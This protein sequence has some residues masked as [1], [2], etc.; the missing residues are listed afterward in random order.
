MFAFENRKEEFLGFFDMQVDADL[1]FEVLYDFEVVRT[2]LVGSEVHLLV[3]VFVD[4]QKKVLLC[5][6][7]DV[8]GTEFKEVIHIIFQ[9]SCG[10]VIEVST[11]DIT[12]VAGKAK[13]ARRDDRFVIDWRSFVPEVTPCGG[14]IDYYIPQKVF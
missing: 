11:E 3:Q 4:D 13:L 10:R 9:A 2:E 7:Y 5:E 12:S 1:E 6:H 8:N 14:L